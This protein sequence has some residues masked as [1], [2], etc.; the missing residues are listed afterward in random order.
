MACLH[1]AL[2]GHAHASENTLLAMR[3]L[4]LI[5][6]NKQQLEIHDLSFLIVV[7]FLKKIF[8]ILLNILISGP[9]VITQYFNKENHM[10]IG[11]F[12]IYP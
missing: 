11:E 3:W 7:I 1:S 6:I 9:S 10:K 2:P 4:Q 5:K 12:R 8:L